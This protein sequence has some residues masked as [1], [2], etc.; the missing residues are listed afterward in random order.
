MPILEQEFNIQ[1][2]AAS[3]FHSTFNL[4]NVFFNRIEEITD[5]TYKE[6]LEMK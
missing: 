6:K 4:M 2:I 5:L 1:E 3:E